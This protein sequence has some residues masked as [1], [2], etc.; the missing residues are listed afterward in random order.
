MNNPKKLLTNLAIV[1]AASAVG[2]GLM[3]GLDLGGNRL[4]KFICYVIFFASILSPSLLFPNSSC[5]IMSRL[6]RRS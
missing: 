6:R 3:T 5:S 4:L 1:I 2:A